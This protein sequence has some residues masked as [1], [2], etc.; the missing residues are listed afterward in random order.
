MTLAYQI[1]K[2]LYENGDEEIRNYVI[3]VLESEALKRGIRNTVI[4]PNNVN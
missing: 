4:N 1:L 2:Y 3:Y